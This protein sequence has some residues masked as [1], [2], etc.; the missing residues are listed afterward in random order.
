MIFKGSY[1]KSIFLLTILL[2]YVSFPCSALPNREVDYILIINSY[3]ESTP[4]SHVFTTPIYEHIISDK[5]S[6]NAYTEHMDVMLMRT[7]ADVENFAS[8]LFDKYTTPPKL[9]ILLG[10]SSYA[11]L[12]D[13]LNEKWGADLS[14]LLCVEKDYLAPREYYLSKKACPMPERQNLSDIVRSVR[15]LTIVYV[16]EYITETVSLMRLSNP[17]MRRLL[18]LS[19]KRYISAQNQSLIQQAMA[20]NFPDI[21]LELITAGET[22][23]EELIDI[24]QKADKQTGVLYYSWILLYAQGNKEVLSSD[25]YRMLSSYTDLPIFTLNDMDIVE[26]GMAGG[27]FFPASTISYT[28]INTIDELLRGGEI[29]KIITPGQ[30]Y[31]VLN[32]PILVARG[33]STSGY[34]KDTLFYMRPPTFWEEYGYYVGV[35]IGTFLFIAFALF[36]RIR[37]LNRTRLYQEKE[38]M[39]MRNYSRLINSMPICYMKQRVLFDEKGYPVDYVILEVNPALEV[40]LKGDKSYVGRKGSEGHPLQMTQY[41][42]A[43]HLIFSENKKINTQYYYKPTDRYFN[44]LIVSASTP[45][46][47]D[48]FMVDVSELVQTQQVLRTVNQKLSMSL[49]VANVT[50]WK[51]DL[52]QHTI[53]CDVNKAVNVNFSGLFDENQLMVPDTEYFSK[54]YKEDREKVR[55]AYESLILGKVNKIKE[56][57]RI[58]N[59]NKGLHGLEW[60]EACAAVEKKDEN[61]KP[62]TLVGSSLIISDRKEVERELLE[63]KNKAEESN[64]LKSAFLAN[65]SHEIRTPLN[66]IVGFSNILAETD[67]LEEKQEYAEIIE[68]NNALL[69]QLINDILDLSKIEAGTLEFVYSDVDVNT[70]LSDLERSMSKRVVNENVRLV[71][72]RKE[73]DC[74]VSIA[75]NRLMQVIINLLTNAIKFTDQGSISYGYSCLNKKMLRF[76]VSDTGRGISVEQ[77]EAIF[78]RFVK[79][80]S[81]AQGTGLGLSICRMIVDHLGG[82]MGVE[83]EIGK[84]STFWFTFPYKAPEKP[85]REDVIFEKIKVEKD[86]LTVL[87][88]EDNAG[89]F[90]LFETILKNDYTIVHAWNGKEAVELFKEYEPHIVLMDINMP[91]MNGYE[92]TKEIRKLSEVIP[93]IAV[94][95]YAFAS[96]EEQVMNSGFDA[97]ASKPLNA[98]ALKK[99]MVDLL[100]ARVFVI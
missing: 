46:C 38:I 90:K 21:K 22:Q 75:K 65:M 23:T 9:V 36:A 6:M 88:A 33:V 29:D 31:P 100:R 12:K 99:Q 80:D 55:K 10:N 53:L 57:Y 50:P 34:P 30:P 81:F 69:L 66:A 7:E 59:P 13:R 73:K 20:T 64:R 52:V 40:L 97:Y 86:K 74:Y 18:F 78:D 98:S 17:D 2:M 42:K 77:Q 27:F 47:L 94:T 45:G 58:Y 95:A 44:I 91:E 48:I 28:L 25:T 89:N 56:E 61:G 92:A 4:W 79:L 26:N 84:G 68:N 63:A 93:I 19:D 24:L 87:I 14:Y 16:P 39:F 8:Y 1:H 60:V 41:L 32:Y 35:G 11:L 54:I 3:T 15:R 76:Y 72:E 96:D 62:L 71:F 82:E 85:V 5:E 67:V 43:C 51:W 49:D 37:S 70:L 83:S